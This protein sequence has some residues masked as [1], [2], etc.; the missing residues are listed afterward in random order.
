MCGIFISN[1]PDVTQKSENYFTRID[2]RGPDGSSGL[3]DRGV[4]SHTIA[5]S[6]IIYWLGQTS[7]L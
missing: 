4:G 7:L 3:I 5:D 2:F 6:P 1:H